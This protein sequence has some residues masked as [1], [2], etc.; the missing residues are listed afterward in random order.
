MNDEALTQKV[1]ELGIRLY[2]GAF[3]E[4][5]LLA[6]W[7]DHLINSGDINRLLSVNAHNLSSFFQL[8][9]LPRNMLAYTVKDGAI[10]SAH[11]V[12]PVGTS[13]VAVFFSSWCCEEMRGR[14]QHAILMTTIYEIIFA[15]GKKTIIG[16]TK[17]ESLL[18]LHAKMGYVILDPVPNLFDLDSAWIMYL[19]K[20]NFERSRLYAVANKIANKEY[21]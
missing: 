15:M 5:Y 4:D 2:R 10:E 6:Q 14:K 20:D 18:D 21:N 1:V 7:W 17:Q 9:E 16:I 3:D 8:F 19:T 11:W 12:E 13:E